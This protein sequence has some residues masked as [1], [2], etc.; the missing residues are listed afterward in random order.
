MDPRSLWDFNYPT[1]SERRFRETAETTTGRE[2]DV[3]LTQVA[4][5]LGLQERYDEGMPSST[6]W[7]RGDPRWMSGSPSRRPTA[8]LRG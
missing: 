7:R 2:R 5:A 3:L 8:P 6:L 1:A 4:R